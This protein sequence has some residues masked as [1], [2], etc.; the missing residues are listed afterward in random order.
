MAPDEARDAGPARVLHLAD[1]AAWS[2]A[3][4]TGTYRGSTRGLAVEDVGF[5]H[6]STATQLPAVLAFLYS[7]VPAGELV[8]LVVGLAELADHGIEVRWENLDGG[9]EP[10]PHAYGPLPLAAVVA[11]LDVEGTAGALTLPDLSGL[12]VV[13]GPPTQ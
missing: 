3:R 10:Y 11:T 13:Q 9:A 1:R 6:M 12:G 2:A 4:A 8:L 5:V 7:D